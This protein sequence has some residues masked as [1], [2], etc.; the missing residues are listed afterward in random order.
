[1]ETQGSQSKQPTTTS[2]ALTTSL[3]LKQPSRSPARADDMRLLEAVQEFEVES[4]LYSVR[5]KDP[6]HGQTVTAKQRPQFN[7]SCIFVGAIL[8]GEEVS[9]QVCIGS[10]SLPSHQ[11]HNPRKP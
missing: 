6:Y 4:E 1:M 10:W 3:N 9:Y 11:A 7:S 8:G 5:I 2:P